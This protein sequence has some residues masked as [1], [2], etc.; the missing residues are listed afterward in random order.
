VTP[1]I[2]PSISLPNAF[3]LSEPGA[4]PLFKFVLICGRG[5]GPVML[6]FIGPDLWPFI[7]LLL[8]RR[9]MVCPFIDCA[10]K[11]FPLIATP[12]PLPAKLPP[13]A[14]FPKPCALNAGESNLAFSLSSPMPS[15]SGQKR[16][17]SQH[18][19]RKISSQR[20]ISSLPS[21][22]VVVLASSSTR[23][24]VASTN[25]LKACEVQFGIRTWWRATMWE[26]AE[27]VEM[28]V[29]KEEAYCQAER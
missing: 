28:E 8:I 26:S 21:C 27:G 7:P 13:S 25:L 16:S 22:A 1:S 12:I 4:A 17:S 24:R 18:I 6:V 14:P 9:F 11:P 2:P 23:E 3:L 10:F 20:D 29:L 15:T 19:W 5:R